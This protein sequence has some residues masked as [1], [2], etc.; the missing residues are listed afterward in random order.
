MATGTLL[1]GCYDVLETLKDTA[2]WVSPAQW[3]G[4]IMFIETS[5]SMMPPY[6]FLQILRNYA[7]SG[8]LHNINGLLIGRPYH[9]KYVKEY[10][11]AIIQ[12]IKKEAG[13]TELPII[14]EAD[15][16]HTCPTFTIPYGIKAE[17]NP[18]AKTFAILE[19]AVI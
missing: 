18:D 9:N 2:I 6:L 11:E 1:G 19:N 3:K 7:A 15:F 5:E 10:E 16:G 17:I 8:I 4:T 14:T 13:L 12:V